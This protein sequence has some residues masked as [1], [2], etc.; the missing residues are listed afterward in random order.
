[1]TAFILNLIGTMRC[2]FLRFESVDGNL[3][4]HFGLWWYGHYAFV[5][6]GAQAWLYEGCFPYPDMVAMDS[7]WKAA[8]AFDVIVLIG[9][10]IYVFLGAVSACAPSG[11]VERPHSIVGVCLLF[12]CFFSGLTLL[13]LDSTLC[14]NN[15]LLGELGRIVFNDQCE[16]S[17]GANC[18]ISATVFWFVA[19]LCTLFASRSKNDENDEMGGG[20]LGEPLIHEGP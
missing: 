2:Q 19:A 6:T 10:L 11:K 20:T 3:T 16:L 15:I 17:T 4:R 13:V 1:M 8:R 9:G 5:T 12:L 7:K 14:K 18:F